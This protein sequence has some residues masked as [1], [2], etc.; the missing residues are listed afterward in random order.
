MGSSESQAHLLSVKYDS[1]GEGIIKDVTLGSDLKGLRI[2]LMP[3]PK[4]FLI[5]STTGDLEAKAGMIC[6]GFMKGKWTNDPSQEVLDR[7]I[8]AEFAD[9]RTLVLMDRKPNSIGELVEDLRR[10]KGVARI[11][12]HKVIEAPL[13]EDPAYFRLECVTNVFWNMDSLKLEEDAETKDRVV[14]QSGLAAAFPIG[15]WKSSVVD[16]SWMVRWTAAGLTPIKPV[17]LF[18]RDLTV[19][20]GLAVLISGNSG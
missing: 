12:Y 1:L 9:S 13:A 2:R 10:T 16:V 8:R 14:L 11:R 19:Q 20:A 15:T 18:T 3:G 17:V 5:N 6:A 4:V 7:S